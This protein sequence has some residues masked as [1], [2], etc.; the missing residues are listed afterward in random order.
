MTLI[1]LFRRE[2]SREVEVTRGVLERVPDER[3]DWKPHTKSFSLGQLAQ[4]VATLPQWASMLAQDSLDI[5]PV[6]QP[7]MRQTP[8]LN[9]GEL[10]ALLEG[11]AAKGCGVSR[12]RERRRARSTLD[13]AGGWP[14]RLHDD[15]GRGVPVVS[16]EPPGA[17]P[18]T[19]VHVSAPERRAGA[20]RLWP[21]RGRADRDLDVGCSAGC[22]A[23]GGYLLAR[24]VSVVV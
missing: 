19:V 13:A 16:D 24:G 2:Y 21:L 17:S 3:F 7:P 22:V 10:L 1:D 8:C 14:H 20:G 9:R 12:E 11:N 15:Q 4:H 23:A 5:Q 18:G 6:G